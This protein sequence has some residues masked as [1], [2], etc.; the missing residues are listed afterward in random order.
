MEFYSPRAYEYIRE[1]FSNNL[2]HRST[3][4]KW[5]ANSCASGVPGFC[6][7]SFSEL[8]RLANDAKANGTE[9]ICS[10][11]FDEVAIRKHLQWSHS[12]KKFL[13][14]ITYG[15]RPDAVEMAIANNALVFML[16]GVNSKMTLPM[17]YY[18]I[19]ALTAEEKS[20]LLQEVISAISACGVRV[21]SVTFD[22][23][24]TNLTTCKLLG[25]S[26]DLKNFKPYFMLANDERKIYIFLDPSHMLKLARNLIAG[27]SFLTSEEGKIE[28]KYFEKLEE[29]RANQNFTLTHKLTKKHIFWK[30]FRMN[31]RVAAETLSNSVANS[32]EYLMRTGHAEFSGCSATVRYTRCINNIFDIMN[33]TELKKGNSFKNPINP[34]TANEI[35]AYFNE[36]VGFLRKIKMPDGTLVIKSKKKTAFMGLITNM[37]NFRP[38]YEELVQTNSMD[39]LPTHTVSQDMLESFFGRIR[40]RLGSNDNPTAEQFASAYR[41]VVINQDIKASKHSNCRDSLSLD[42]F[43]VSSRRSKIS[44]NDASSEEISVDSTQA[45]CTVN[46]GYELTDLENVSVAYLAGLIEAK[47]EQNGRFNCNE[48]REIFSEN[49]KITQTTEFNRAPCQ[50]TF[51]ICSIAHKHAQKMVSDSSYTYD[52]L[53]KDVRREFDHTTAFAN[54]N[55][56]GHEDHQLFFSL[57]VAEEYIRAQ[58]TY[59]AKKVTLREQAILIGKKHNK[60]RQFNGQ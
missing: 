37:V 24:F 31:V 53:L 5:Y 9:F 52:M 18:F 8:T 39:F 27:S 41:K 48:C 13:G 3:N 46:D 51:D 49:I 29:A 21:I 19:G 35:F 54:T 58:A 56:S 36:A 15:F 34:S 2:P 42:I 59:I 25:A 23:L 32:I 14:H 45:K 57:F 40:S 1:I 12:Q 60:Y 28:W 33:T 7:Q 43:T 10:L 22:G 4:R 16:N 55:F 44:D 38:M 17:A 50:S 6:K 20:K 47:I 30:K 26:F 11:S